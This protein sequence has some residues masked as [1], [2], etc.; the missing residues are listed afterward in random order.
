VEIRHEEH[1]TRGEFFIE[2][3]GRRVARQTYARRDVKAQFEKD[4]AIRDV[5][6]SA[7]PVS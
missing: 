5:Y 7:A 6:E 1:G 2:R 3:D 4:P